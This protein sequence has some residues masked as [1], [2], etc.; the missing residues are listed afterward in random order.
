[1]DPWDL[2]E[3]CWALRIHEEQVNYSRSSIINL[4]P[5]LH[6]LEQKIT[7]HMASIM[8]SLL[9]LK[10]QIEV[11]EAECNVLRNLALNLCKGE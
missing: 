9:E 2:Q 4:V 1:M 10:K 11:V 5:K 8:G 3:I 6:E 7:S